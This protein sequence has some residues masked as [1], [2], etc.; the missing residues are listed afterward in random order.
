MYKIYN[1]EFKTQKDIKDYLTDVIKNN[2]NKIID[3]DNFVIFKELIQFVPAYRDMR[4]E[5]TEMIGKV[6]TDKLM[7]ES[8]RVDFN[9]HRL[10][11]NRKTKYEDKKEY[12]YVGSIV[13]YAPP[14][15]ETTINYVF[16]FGKYKGMSIEDIN[17]MS[18]LYWI[19]GENSNLN[20]ND[21][22]LIKKFIRY[23]FI[24]YNVP[25]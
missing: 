23:G 22:I 24:P 1:K 25:Y 6:M 13:Q 3:G 2:D 18:Y 20:K 11:Y 10:R 9:V 17:D 5:I 4:G 12:I 19:T 14:V 16:K 15:K 21:K 8:Y 7:R